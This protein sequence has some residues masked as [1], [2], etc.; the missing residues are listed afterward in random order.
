VISCEPF[1]CL[2]REP[3]L[4]R[5]PSGYE[6]K[7]IIYIWGEAWDKL[8]VA[9]DDLIPEMPV[10]VFCAEGDPLPEFLSEFA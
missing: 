10:S 2:L 9:L 7:K 5:R 8:M 6:A 1:V 4:N 3:D